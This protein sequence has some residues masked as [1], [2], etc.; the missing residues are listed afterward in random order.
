MTVDYADLIYSDE[1]MQQLIRM[2]RP[3]N[4][5]DETLAY[6]N[7]VEVG[8]GKTFLETDHTLDNYQ[9]EIWAPKLIERSTWESWC[10]RGMKDI[11]Q[12]SLEKARQ[13]YHELENH[14]ILPEEVR[15]AIDAIA[16]ASVDKAKNIKR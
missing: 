8:H 12:V 14:E 1:C 9:D 10:E 13:M 2:V 11:R 3:L 4:F 7:M 5:D 6:E 16:E 15:Q